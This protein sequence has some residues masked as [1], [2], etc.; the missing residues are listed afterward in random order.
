MFY[1]SFFFFSTRDLR[2]LLADRREILP[3]GQKRVQ[4]TNASTKIWEPTSEKNL[5]TKKR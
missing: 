1:N 5:G 2:G 3:H 4:F